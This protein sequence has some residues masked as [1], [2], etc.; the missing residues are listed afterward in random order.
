MSTDLIDLAEDVTALHENLPSV[1]RTRP[2]NH[3]QPHDINNRDVGATGRSVQL[4]EIASD[5]GHLPSLHPLCARMAGWRSATG[6]GLSSGRR[7]HLK[8]PRLAHRGAAV[9][10]SW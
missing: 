8:T 3:R 7:A 6:T 10:Y 5:N 9:L 1:K 2:A 4:L